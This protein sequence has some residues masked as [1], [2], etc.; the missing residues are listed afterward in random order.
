MKVLWL[1]SWFPNK[2][3]PFD[4]DFIE[5]QA[6]ALSRHLPLTVLFV[7]KDASLTKGNFVVEKSVTGNLSVYRVYY[8]PSSGNSYIEKISSFRKYRQLQK[9][10]YKDIVNE[11]GIPDMV[12]VHVAMKAGMLALYLLKKFRIPFI[13]TEHWSGYYPHCS[14]SVYSGNILLNRLNKKVL[15]AAT[16]MI[17]VSR[18]LGDTINKNFVPIPYEA[19]PNVVDTS[20]FFYKPFTAQH[21]RFIH[22]SGLIDVKN[23]EGILAA[24]KRVKEKGYVFE[25]LMMGAENAALQAKAAVL[26]LEDT[27]SFRGTVSYT[28]VAAAMQQ[29]SALLLFSRHENMSCVMLEALCCG[30]PVIAT[31]VG[32][33]PEVIN[34]TNGILVE[35]ENA[36]Q[37]AA[38]MIE[39]MENEPRY[40]RASIAATAQQQFNYDAVA[41][42]HLDV[43]AQLLNEQRG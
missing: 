21:F 19:I 24:C 4:G 31:R 3:N 6:L 38:A 9:K 22:P 12:H 42:M 5:R 18:H 23:P 7:V 37:L 33:L 8:G 34:D 2:T 16:K 32:G 35:S 41:K 43:Y 10:V 1:A 11:T 17:T 13:V 36:E 20:A 40:N 39:M 26:G 28:E 30:L 15:Q 14:P 27:V 29:S 25:L